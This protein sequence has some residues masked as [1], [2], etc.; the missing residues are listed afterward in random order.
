MTPLALPAPSRSRDRARRQQAALNVLRSHQAFT[1]HWSDELPT[2][3]APWL[4]C[5]QWSCPGYTSPVTSG[6]T[7]A[8]TKSQ[9]LA[10]HKEQAIAV[11][12]LLKGFHPKLLT[13]HVVGR[14]AS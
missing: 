9:A 6:I 8:S 11:E 7:I 3:T 13:A 14:R 5:Y 1:I 4:V 2:T 12:P 10:L